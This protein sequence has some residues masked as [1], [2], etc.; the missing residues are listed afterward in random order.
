MADFTTW[1]NESLAQ[2]AIAATN[3]IK[4]Q[5]AEIEALQ[6]DLRMLLIAYRALLTSSHLETTPP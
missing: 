5:D 3:R 4:Q 1:N 6:A 2:F